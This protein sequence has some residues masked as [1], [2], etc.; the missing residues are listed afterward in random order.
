M[1]T[2]FFLTSSGCRFVVMLIAAL[3]L[4]AGCRQHVTGSPIRISHFNLLK[5]MFE[6]GQQFDLTGI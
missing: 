4:F 5:I 6:S 3:S 2:R 1:K